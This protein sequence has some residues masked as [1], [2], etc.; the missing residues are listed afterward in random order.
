MRL[1]NRFR[2]HF[3][4]VSSKKPNLKKVIAILVLFFIFSLVLK[5]LS[6]I[7]SEPQS[8][9]WYHDTNPSLTQRSS[10]VF[11]TLTIDDSGSTGNGTWSWATT[12]PWC[13]GNGSYVNP[14]IIEN[15]IIN[16]T[17][18][19]P[20]GIR[21]LDS[22]KYFEIRNCT[23]SNTDTYAIILVRTSNGKI[24]NNTI[25]NNNVGIHLYLECHN[26]LIQNNTIVQNTEAIFLDGG[27]GQPWETI[28]SSNSINN[29]FIAENQYAIRLVSYCELTDITN[30]F[31]INNGYNA[32]DYYAIYVD[33]SRN[34][35]IFNNT[36]TEHKGTAICLNV[37]N[38]GGNISVL[39]NKLLHN[40]FNGIIIA[41]NDILVKGNLI[42]DHA[43]DGIQTGSNANHIL[44]NIL[45]ENEN[46]IYIT[47]QFNWIYNNTFINSNTRHA[48]STWG[49]NNYWNNSEIGN[50]WDDYSS[51]DTNDDGIGDSPYPIINRFGYVYDYRPLWRDGP[52]LNLSAPEQNEVFGTTPPNFTIS[53]NDP[54][55][56]K[57]WYNLTQDTT[58]YIRIIIA[59]G[60]I[61]ASDWADLEDGIVKLT[62]YGN[63]SAGNTNSEQISIFKDAYL[64]NITIIAPNPMKIYAF[65]APDYGIITE[66]GDI[67]MKWYSLSNISYSSDNITVFSST[68]QL[69][70]FFWNK[71]GNGTILLRFYTN[72]SMNN[73]VVDELLL[74]KDIIMPNITIIGPLN[75]ETYRTDPPHFNLSIFEGNLDTIWYTLDGGLTNHTCLVTGQIDPTLWEALPDGLVTIRFYAN[76]TSGNWNFIEISF[77]KESEPPSDGG[78]DN[79]IIL[80]IILLVGIIAA[81]IT[82]RR[83]R[84]GS[85]PLITGERPVWFVKFFGYSPSLENKLEFLSRHPEKV[86]TD[87]ELDE[88]LRQPFTLLSNEI[89]T[90]LD[91]LPYTDEEKSEILDALLMLPPKERQILIDKLNEN[92][93][94]EAAS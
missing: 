77:I 70:P 28:S 10:W 64:P 33:W 54:T 91:R 69:D 89:I 87:S 52:T 94:K 82:Y 5:T 48:D 36:I 8:R 31:L 35:T 86:A 79:F 71:F 57:F 63:D 74:F 83:V 50:F 47:G 81:T 80:L 41:G 12:Q 19:N 53:T 4:G 18:S 34:I 24:I 29:N 65:E 1:K 21:I 40:D 26:N 11:T 42:Q 30:N 46:G 49:D 16:T 68:E 85:S 3:S 6:L 23:I 7:N 55:L 27:D 51:T 2:K 72:D 37:Y 67:S 62:F 92:L 38:M 32:E 15:I 9:T 78:G 76:D 44:D 22:N 61:N 58:F 75:N 20:I 43:G 60:S 73:I 13:G 90:E 14:Y 45:K 25:I 17:T 39:N 66:G 84:R 88:F 59:N 56:S 93:P